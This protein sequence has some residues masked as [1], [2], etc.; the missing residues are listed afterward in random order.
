MNVQIN[1]VSFKAD[2][3]LQDF[4]KGKIEKLLRFYNYAIGSEVTLK[5]DANEKPD[6]KIVEIRFLVKGNDLFA[7]KQCSTFEEAVDQTIDALKR[8]ID[9]RKE[10]L[11]K[12]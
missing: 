2:Q 5:V 8:Q 3:K 9:K 6:N 7:S 11:V 1:S 4:I 10:K 12:K